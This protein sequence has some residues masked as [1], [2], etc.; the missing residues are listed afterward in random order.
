MCIYIY[1]HT[2]LYKQ[3]YIDAMVALYIRTSCSTESQRFARLIG[4]CED[5]QDE[6][7]RQSG[8]LQCIA[9]CCSVLQCIALCCSLLHVLH[10]VANQDNFQSGVWQC[11]ASCCSVLR[12]IAL[13]CSLLHV[14]HC[15]ANQDNFDY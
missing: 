6:F 3:I 8:V 4:N 9:S 1:L 14:L 11:I 5:D 7:H 12:C 10:C 13:C 15:V 2:Y